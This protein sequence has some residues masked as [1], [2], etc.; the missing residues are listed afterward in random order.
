VLSSEDFESVLAT[1]ER[2]APLLRHPALRDHAFTIVLYVRDQ[3]SY[4][5]ALFIELLQHG[6]VT[7]AS[8]VCDQVL[9]EGVLRHRAWAFHFDYIA[10]LHRLRDIEGVSVFVRAYD[11]RAGRSTVADF[12][13]FAALRLHASREATARRVHARP[14]L[15][16]SL[17]AYCGDDGTSVFQQRAYL[18][19]RRRALFAAR[20]DPGNGQLARLAGFPATALGISRTMPPDGLVLE[21]L[22]TGPS[23]RDRA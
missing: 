17:A 5:E 12:L 1:P 6:M 2:L 13:G 20:F 14:D 23:L 19:P 7:P 15:A 10:L 3:V 8:T 18:S 22:F 4:L 21:H 11:G 16:A 9:A